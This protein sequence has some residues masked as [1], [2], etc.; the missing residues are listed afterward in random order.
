MHPQLAMP[1]LSLRGGNIKFW[2]SPKTVQAHYRMVGYSPVTWSMALSHSWL[3]SS[4]VEAMHCTPCESDVSGISR[5]ENWQWL[6]TLQC[7]LVEQRWVVNKRKIYLWRNKRQ[8]TYA[9]KS[10]SPHLPR[11]ILLRCHLGRAN[12][13][14]SKPSGQKAPLFHEENSEMNPI[15]SRLQCWQHNPHSV[16][17]RTQHPRHR[18]W[19]GWYQHIFQLS[20]NVHKW[21]FSS[22]LEV[23]RNYWNISISSITSVLVQPDVI[24][25]AHLLCAKFQLHT[26]QG[27]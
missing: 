6:Q 13:G 16:L 3:L 20:K 27:R 4:S 15:L 25:I 10:E 19:E 23:L 5:A 18:W 1:I 26:G 14:V 8:W 9:K 2:D 7:F 17:D 12:P 24:D 21:C 22:Y 11:S